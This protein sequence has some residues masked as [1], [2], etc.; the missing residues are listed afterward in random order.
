[1]IDRLTT[2]T[3]RQ[4]K[5]DMRLSQK[6]MI[7]NKIF[8]ILAFLMCYSMSQ[9]QSRLIGER[10]V[11]TQYF[12]SPYL[13]HPGATGQNQYGEVLAIYRNT[14]ASFPG[15]PRTLAFGFE[16]PIG[17]RIGIGVVAMS[18]RFAAF[19]TTKGTVNISYTVSSPDYKIGF[20]IAGDYVQ[21]KLGSDA[22]ISQFVDLTDPEI[23]T[24][25]DGTSYFDGS[26]GVYGTF[27]DKIVFGATLPSII[28]Q[29]ISGVDGGTSGNL[30]FIASV[31]LIHDIP[32]NDIK[33]EPSVYVKRF[34]YVPLHVDVNVKASFLR[35]QLT[36]G[37][38]Y[39]TLEKRIGFLIGTQVKNFG[40]YYSYNASL[41]DFQQY[42]NGSHEL[43]LK[44]RLQPFREAE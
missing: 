2:L 25:L 33:I 29:R 11:Y 38:T 20:G 24:R 35:E 41:H 39:S 17:N 5:I 32:Q 22:L 14:W 34:Q 9:A 21:H 13:L 15:S 30:G 3:Y 43:S 40:F 12:L 7:M 6:K 28:S 23:L 44:L 18:D 16:G 19:E 37:L 31:G 1:M 8:I 27:K 10:S 4:E 42:S 26:F 36:T